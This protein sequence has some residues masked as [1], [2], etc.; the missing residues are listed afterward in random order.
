MKGGVAAI[1]TILAEAVESLLPHLNV[2]LRRKER[3]EIR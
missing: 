2:A 1:R 3:K